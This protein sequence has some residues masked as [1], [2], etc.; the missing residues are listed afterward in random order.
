MRNRNFI[1]NWIILLVL[2]AIVGYFGVT[3]YMSSQLDPVDANN[4]TPQAFVITKGQPMNEILANLKS[5]G[6]IRSEFAFRQYLKQQGLD[7]K[8]QAG[9]YKLSPS[10]SAE[11]L[12]K[13]FQSGAEDR[14]VTILE[15]WR[16]EEIADVLE[17][18]LGMDKKAFLKVAKEGYMFP[19]TYLINKEASPETVASLLKNTFDQRYTDEL[20]SKIKA[21]GLTAGQGVILASM[22]EREARSDE[23]RTQVASIMLRRLKE[24]TVLN[25]D[26]TIQY[27]LG[28]QPSE[29]SWWKK[30]LTYDD[31][32]IDSPYNSY[33]Q[34]GLPP[35][36]ISNPSLSSLK[37]V[38]NATANT[39]YFYYF[40]DSQGNTYYAKTLEEHNQNIA[41]HR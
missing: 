32:K 16:V 37:A 30:S 3:K 11:E 40:H 23:V 33:T 22:V 4:T 17:K 7:G 18:D 27:A 41:N 34:I 9:D 14:W 36:P 31:L 15:G 35:T 21:K 6:L 8:I 25:I 2:L 20:Q 26:A 1:R 12:V 10:M 5:K 28:Y 38:A 13:A 29:K 19:D 39:P 24:G